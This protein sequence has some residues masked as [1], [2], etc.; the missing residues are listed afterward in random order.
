MKKKIFI[1]TALLISGLCANA[2]NWQPVNTYINGIDLYIDTDSIQ[3]INNDECLYAIKYSV[4]GNPEKIAYIKS[5]SKTNYAGIINSGD[6]E[7]EK[8]RPIAVFADP[9]VY[10]KPINKNSFL[11]NAHEYAIAAANGNTYARHQDAFTANEYAATYSY[12][13]KPILRDDLQVAYN[14]AKTQELLTP[15][16]LQEYV[17]RTCKYLEANWNPPVSGRGTRAII[18]LTIGKDGSLID[19]NF[20]EASGDNVTDRSIITAVERTVPYP[21]F[22]EIAKN[23][24]SLDFQFVFEHDLI[25]KSVVY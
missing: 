3:K 13:E 9:R 25:K 18:L 12:N 8:Y 15:A 14:Q 24:Y 22:P 6:Y 17:I 19:Y 7:I 2:M 11:L 16:Q 1:L 4:N 23:A 5:N 10:M 21:K 20:K